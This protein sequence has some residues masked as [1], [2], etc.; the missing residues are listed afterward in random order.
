LALAALDQRPNAVRN[1]AALLAPCDRLPA[2]LHEEH[3][4]HPFV[5][6]GLLAPQVQ[7]PKPSSWID[8]DYNQAGVI[9]LAGHH[10]KIT[11]SEDLE[12]IARRKRLIRFQPLRLEKVAALW[13]RPLLKQCA[14]VPGR[15]GLLLAA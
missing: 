2:P 10:G 3:L 9:T 12:H 11:A 4:L 5:R 7:Q 13:R 6:R 8:A 14:P 15:L 1:L